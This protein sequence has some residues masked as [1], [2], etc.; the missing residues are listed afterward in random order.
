[1]GHSKQKFLIS[2]MLVVIILVMPVAAWMQGWSSRM[3]IKIA[4]SNSHINFT[5]YQVNITFSSPDFDFSK[6]NI[7]GS[8]I[9]FVRVN[10]SEEQMLSFWIENWNSSGSNGNATIWVNL[11]FLNISTTEN[12]YMYYGNAS[13]VSA[14]NP[15]DTFGSSSANLSIPGCTLNE[16]CIVSSNQV[17]NSSG[18]YGHP[19][20]RINP[21]VTL[22]IT[23][24]NTIVY[25]NSTGRF[26]I[27]GALSSTGGGASNGTT[28]GVYRGRGSG[29]AGGT[30]NNAALLG[31]TFGG[32]GSAKGGT[33]CS[34]GG[35]SFGG[36]GG[37]ACDAGNGG[38]GG[39]G[40]FLSVNSSVINIKPNG[41]IIITGA[42]GAGATGGGGGALL[43]LL[44][45]STFIMDGAITVAGGDGASVGVIG[46]GGGGGALSY[47]NNHSVTL[48]FGTLTVNA[49]HGPVS[50]GSGGVATSNMQDS[51]QSS[52]VDGSIAQPFSMG[53]SEP[54]VQISLFDELR[55]SSSVQ[56][57]IAEIGSTATIQLNYTYASNSSPITGAS[58]NLTLFD[59]TPSRAILTGRLPMTYSPSV[60]LWQ[61]NYTTPAGVNG[62]YKYNINGSVPGLFGSDFDTNGTFDTKDTTAPQISGANAATSCSGHSNYR[63]ANA[64]FDVTFLATDNWEIN[65][66]FS[67]CNFTMP[68]GTG[69]AVF[70]ANDS[71]KCSFPTS[72][73]AGSASIRISVN[74]TANNTASASLAITVVDSCPVTYT[75]PSGSSS[76]G[77]SGGGGG[78]GGGGLSIVS[79][80]I[81]E[82][83]EIL[84][85]TRF[86]SL[87][88]GQPEKL[89]IT[90]KNPKNEPLTV[91]LDGPPE[92]SFAE[93]EIVLSAGEVK[94]V[95]TTLS[96]SL[97]GEYKPMISAQLGDLKRVYDLSVTVMKEEVDVVEQL[98]IDAQKAVNSL[99]LLKGKACGDD[100][101]SLKGKAIAIETLA[102]D[103]R[104]AL[105]SKS[106]PPAAKI[107]ELKKE[108]STITDFTAGI[109]E[110]KPTV[111]QQK[112]TA[113]EVVQK[114]KKAGNMIPAMAVLVLLFGFGLFRFL[115]RA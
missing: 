29:G 24:A 114:P 20:I 1:M 46:C 25:F 94:E 62:T 63:L 83:P 11:P 16:P 77:S 89:K 14:S 97:Q 107:E 112:S 75:P 78:S 38:I 19:Y 26:D 86:L 28:G 9:R 109:G 66:T 3:A 79:A 17:I 102:G 65:R 41:K 4:N 106:T 108:L 88:Q 51:S 18:N 95:F 10:G 15:I 53:G 35:G 13:A 47:I 80:A 91:T 96:Y 57:F 39:V 103:V 40:A 68:N 64:P 71:N 70:V 55:H 69:T 92:V 12:I 49:G 72:G 36:G 34:T 59:T 22:S 33:S 37:N 30:G 44:N 93:R 74:D 2:A 100:V 7:D 99:I 58:V 27:L 115:R 67:F 87:V 73:P 113:G 48:G 43:Q 50:C 84:F 98:L 81:S 54:T 56:P 8:D 45:V 32:G 60:G 6:T 110:C 82:L 76:G 90:L 31:G 111:I 85:E 42:S 105:L 21:E 104:S 52:A 23:G 61:Y 5:N 101:D